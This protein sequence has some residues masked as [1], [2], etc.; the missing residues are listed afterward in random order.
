MIKPRFD[1]QLKLWPGWGFP[2]GGAKRSGHR[3][4]AR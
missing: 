4:A 1:P 3:P 2:A